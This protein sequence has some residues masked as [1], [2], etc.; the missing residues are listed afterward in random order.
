MNNIHNLYVQKSELEE[1]IARKKEILAEVNADIRSHHY[2]NE[3]LKRGEKKYGNCWI[4]DGNYDLCI[5]VPRYWKY[6]NE[7]MRVV[8]DALYQKGINPGDGHIKAKYEVPSHI[9]NGFPD[10]IRALVDEARTP[11]YGTPKI[12]IKQRELSE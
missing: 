6:D 5:N 10:D 8:I 2:K 9:Y 4:S 3:M 12:Y 1:E 11:S 7:K